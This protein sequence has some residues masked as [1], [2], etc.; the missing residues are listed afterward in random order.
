ML[1][2]PA[3]SDQRPPRPAS[4]SGMARPMAA[5]SAPEES[6]SLAPVSTRTVAMTS[7][8]PPM[9]AGQY[10]AG[11]PLAMEALNLGCG[12]VMTVMPTPPQ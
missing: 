12:G 5:A 11:R 7:S 9:T 3:R 2:T 8:E 10:Q 1:T 6:M 4:A